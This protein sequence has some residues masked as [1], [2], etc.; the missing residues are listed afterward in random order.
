MVAFSSGDSGKGPPISELGINQTRHALSHH[1]RDLEQ[2]ARLT[3][4]DAFIMQ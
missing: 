3:Q 4:S 1:N 2:L